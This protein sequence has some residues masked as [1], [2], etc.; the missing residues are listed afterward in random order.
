MPISRD[1]YNREVT[2]ASKVD[3]RDEDEDEDIELMGTGVVCFLYREGYVTSLVLLSAIRARSLYL[4]LP[5]RNHVPS[6]RLAEQL[7]ILAA[8]YP[9]TKF[10]SIVGDKCIPNYPDRMLPTLIL[11]RNG[12]IKEQLVAWGTKREGTLEG[13]YSRVSLYS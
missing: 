5:C 7:R 10:T 2:E 3:G 1:D 8:R 12:E 6:V 11:Y 4:F 9:Q 13:T